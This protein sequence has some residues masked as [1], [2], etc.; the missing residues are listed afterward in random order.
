MHGRAW[1]D[2]TS[3][4]K[5]LWDIAKRNIQNDKRKLMCAKNLG[6]LYVVF[7]DDQMATWPEKLKEFYEKA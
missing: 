1:H 4:N 2:V 6:A 7:W 3:K 5:R